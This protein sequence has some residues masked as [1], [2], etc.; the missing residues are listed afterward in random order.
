[1]ASVSITKTPSAVDEKLPP[2][3]LVLAGAQHLL[4][5]YA[6]IAA[7]PLVLAVALGLAVMV[8]FSIVRPL[9]R[10]RN[11]TLLAA[12]QSLPEAIAA[13]YA[14]VEKIH[15]DNA[16]YRN[17]IGAKALKAGRN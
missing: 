13:S 1:M 10:L 7:A 9:R 16:Y 11:D 17:D 3:K 5:M 12:E 4:A 2:V 14:K 8:A 6:S 15:F